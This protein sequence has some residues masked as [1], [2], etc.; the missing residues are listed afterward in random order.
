MG[1]LEKYSEKANKDGRRVQRNRLASKLSGGR[2]ICFFFRVVINLPL[3]ACDTGALSI[4]PKN[5]V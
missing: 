3:K 2:G 5:P 4:Q 1:H